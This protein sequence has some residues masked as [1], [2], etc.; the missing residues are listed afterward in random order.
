MQRLVPVAFASQLWLLAATTVGIGQ[1]QTVTS[2]AVAVVVTEEHVIDM[3]GMNM[4]ARHPGLLKVICYVYG[5]A[6]T[7]WCFRSFRLTKIFVERD[8]QR[9]IYFL[10]GFLKQI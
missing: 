3:A 7:A 1:Q 8:F 6:R 9:F 5:I 2:L 4:S 10:K